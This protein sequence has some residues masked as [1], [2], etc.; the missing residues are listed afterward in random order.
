MQLYLGLDPGGSKCQ[1][2][3]VRAD[4]E[5]LG[6][7]SF[8][9]AGLSGRS[10]ASIRAAAQQALAGLAERPAGVLSVGDPA[11]NGFFRSWPCT[12][13]N[14][15]LE[16]QDLLASPE[17][18]FLFATEW[19]GALAG[20]GATAGL[21]ALAGTG[22]V[23]YGRTADG[24]SLRLDGLGPILG[25]YGSAYAIGLAALR[26]AGRHGWHP[27]HATSLHARILARLGLRDV[28]ELVQFSLQVHDRSLI[29]A[30]AQLVDD[31]ARQ[32][33]PL[34]RRL[35][36][37]AA[38]SLAESLRDVATQLDL[39]GSDCPL[40]GTGSVASG[41]ALYWARLC[42]SVA[43]FAPRVR[44][45]L[46]PGPPVLGVLTAC[47]ASRCTASQLADFRERL[48]ASYRRC[49]PQGTPA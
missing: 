36:E 44:A 14:V 29:A 37:D 42:R 39:T 10:P 7:G 18:E 5:I 9:Q 26:A 3:V 22:A 1:A 43:A 21:V 16:L 38:D 40:V 33:D 15:R 12:L 47:L 46:P 17:P 4:G 20:A 11:Y 32:G 30:L 45:Q 49:P 13:Q 25:D 27:R 2:A 48:L 24:R 6:W 34:A 35:L 28:N 8:R 31:Q 41:S 19:D 23:A